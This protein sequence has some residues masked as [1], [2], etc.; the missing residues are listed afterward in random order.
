VTRLALLSIFVVFA[1]SCSPARTFGIAWPEVAVEAPSDVGALLADS[2]RLE[3]G[4]PAPY[5]GRLV[6]GQTL[7]A[8]VERIEAQDQALADCVRGRL[9]D[10]ATCSGQLDDCARTIREARR[11]QARAF[12]AGAAVGAGVAGGAVAGAC[13]GARP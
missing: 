3:P 11:A 2:V 10:R 1:L 5:P 6:S 9:L 12:G 7:L 4:E 13:A 8:L